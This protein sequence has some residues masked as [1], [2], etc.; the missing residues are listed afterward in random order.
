MTKP[1]VVAEHAE[2]EIDDAQALSATKGATTHAKFQRAIQDLWTTLAANPGIGAK[3]PRTPFRQF[4]MTG[5]PYYVIY[6]EEPDRIS[7]YVFGHTSRKPNYWKKRLR[8]P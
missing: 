7:V 2:I 8:N 6:Q 1:I 4:P 5:H 3:L